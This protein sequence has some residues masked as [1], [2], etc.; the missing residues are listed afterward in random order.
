MGLEGKRTWSANKYWTFDCHCLSTV[1]SYVQLSII[2]LK[3]VSAKY[4]FKVTPPVF[5]LTVL[6]QVFR[7]FRESPVHFFT[8]PLFSPLGRKQL[9]LHTFAITGTIASTIASTAII[10]ISNTSS[11]RLVDQPW[12]YRSYM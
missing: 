7:G 4:H 2:M 9:Q 11:T 8:V 1:S 3:R 12:A 5:L 6:K 10:M